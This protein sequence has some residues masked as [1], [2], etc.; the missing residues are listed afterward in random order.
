MILPFSA[1]NN[2]S[3]IKFNTD[4]VVIDLFIYFSQFDITTSLV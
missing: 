3:N 2:N 4:F 1:N